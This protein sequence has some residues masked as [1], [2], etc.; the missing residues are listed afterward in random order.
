M[1]IIAGTKRG[2]GLFSPKARVSRPITD[3]VKESLFSVLYKYDLPAG[4]VVADLFAGVGSLGLESLSRGARFVSFVE[5]DP[6]ILSI[7][8]KNIYKSGFGEQCRVTRGNAFR[9]GAPVEGGG[10]KYGLVFVDPPYAAT[11]DAGEDSR[12]GRLMDLLAG[13]VEAGAIAAVRTSERT[14]PAE[15]YGPFDAVERREWGT[16]TVTILRK[17]AG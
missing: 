3:R 8:E 7:L 10:G 6:K 9:L 14:A 17:G 12:L 2:M 1:R 16:M 4:A 5:R 11:E 15:R 13:Q